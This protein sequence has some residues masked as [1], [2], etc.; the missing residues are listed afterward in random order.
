MSSHYT[1]WPVS[2]PSHVSQ[3]R[4]FASHLAT[5]LGFNE[6]G[7]GKVAL[8]VTEAATNIL[9]HAGNGE[10]LIR[11]LVPN[12]HPTSGLEVIA[13][14]KGSGIINLEA[15]MRD[16][17][18][19]AGSPGSGLGAISR[20]ATAFDIYSRPNAGTVL[21][22]QLLTDHANGGK[23]PPIASNGGFNCTAINLPKPGETL[24][25]DGVE[26][27]ACSD[28]SLQALVVDG[29]GHGPL[30]ADAA[31][32][33]ITA[34]KTQEDRSLTRLIESCHTALQGTRGAALA[35]AN[36]DTTKQQVTFVG[37]GNITAFIWSP[38]NIRSLVSH[39]G[40]VGH[41]LH[42]VQEFTYPWSHRALLIMHSDGLNTQM[43]LENYS[44]L[45]SR[46]LGL[47]ASV[48]YRDFNRGRDDAT[49]LVLRERISGP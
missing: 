8:V 2:D 23:M 24:C 48:L 37:V 19:T 12:G 44:D 14:D 26:I 17:Y 4:R 6:I 21:L 35:I 43:K 5:D 49:V 40:T 34:F 27:Y 3:I 33:A 39:N 22:A 30:A 41:Q 18:S 32:R 31:Q 28:G 47:I 45:A 15:A 10:L 13:L 1:A 11:P 46:Q 7:T 38:D 9:K 29:L 42:R 20:L 36:I 16:G 25:G